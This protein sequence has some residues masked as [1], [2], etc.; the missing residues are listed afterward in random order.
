MALPK[1]PRQK[2][3]N[4]M[5]IVLTALLALNVSSEVLNAFKIVNESIKI[6]NHSI[7]QKNQLT[8]EEFAKLLQNDPVRVAPFKAKA[9]QVEILSAEMSRYLDSLKNLII[10]ESGGLND[11][12]EIKSEDNL[13]AATR[14]MENYGNGPRME[15]KIALLR[16]QLL[17]FIQPSKRA[18]FEQTL[19]LR[20]EIPKT[21]DIENNN[22]WT[23]AHFKM[24]P[25]IAAVTI[26]N[27]FKND[28]KNS[29]SMVIDDLLKQVSKPI[30]I[31]DQFKPLVSANSEYVM[32]GQQ[33]AAQIMLGAYSSTVTPT[34]T[35]NGQSIPVKAG[36]GTYSLVAS[37]VG[38][39]QYSVAVSLKDQN[40]MV[41][42]YTTN[43]TYM[44]GAPTVSVSPDYMNVLYIGVN[45]PVTVAAAGVQGQSISAS[46]SQG[47]LLPSSGPGKFLARVTRP[48]Y[49]YINV[50][51]MVDNQMKQLGSVQ[52]RVKYLPDPIPMVG[53]SRGGPIKSGEFK[54]QTGVRA[55]PPGDFEFKV[56]YLVT[57]FTLGISG[58]GFDDYTYDNANGPYFTAKMRSFIA[59]ARP[60]N[61]IYIDDIHAKGPD[62]LSRNLGSISFTLK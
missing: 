42:T 28:V 53:V 29:E 35:V 17:S 46:I 2:M 25:T 51:A 11:S 59:R 39:H 9:D 3:I 47:S 24:V 4:V 16:A 6:S 38:P 15:K 7:D 60:G 52:F 14:V 58:R 13:E 18:E 36:I 33:Y 40:G 31:L 12:G 57:S 45:N 56:N 20:I 41:K 19:P 50:S 48:G 8:Y 22:D 23:L 44:V 1:E 21:H 61:I 5:Y 27:K 43:E 37:G 34:I 30:F 10:S 62:G 54:V 32:T 49:A 55:A 26:I